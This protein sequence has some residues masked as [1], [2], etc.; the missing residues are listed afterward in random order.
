MPIYEHVLLIYF[1]RCKIN[2][3]LAFLWNCINRHERCFITRTT[4]TLIAQRVEH[5]ALTS[6]VAG[7]SPPNDM[8]LAPDFF[9]LL[10]KIILIIHYRNRKVLMQKMISHS[11]FHDFEQDNWVPCSRFLENH[12]SSPRRVVPDL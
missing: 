3:L 6:V 12:W 7:S 4:L 5:R 1:S 2:L 8:Y 9:I 11:D 10:N